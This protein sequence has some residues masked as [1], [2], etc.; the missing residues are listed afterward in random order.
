MFACKL[1]EKNFFKYVK[2][3]RIWVVYYPWKKF[4]KIYGLPATL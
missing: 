4:V 1:Q 3:C 2:K